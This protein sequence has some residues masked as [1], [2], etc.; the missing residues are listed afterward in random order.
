MPK[1]N[2]TRSGVSLDVDGVDFTPEELVAMVLSHAKDIT[3]AF[4]AP[5]VR[6]C[7]MTVPSFYTQ[8]ERQALLD[9][10]ELADLNV[11]GLIDENAA[12]A[13]HYGIDRVD[14]KP[15]TIL[16]YNMGGSS[17]EVSVVRYHSYE[18]KD[19]ISRKKKTVGSFEVLGKG[20]DATLGGKA[21]DAHL[22]DFL[23]TEFNKNPVMEGK[24]IR[25]VPRAMAKLR[26]QANKVK[27]V[28][29]ANTDFPVFVD[30]LY[31]DTGL[32]THIS[33]STFEQLTHELLER[34]VKPIGD[35]LEAA[36]LTLSDID[37]VELIGGGMRIPKVQEMIKS[38]LGE[39]V[40]LGRHINSDEAMALGAAFH[41]ANVSTAF[42]VRQV[43]MTDVNPFEIG[44]E[45]HELD[46]VESSGGFASYFGFGKKKE[47]EKENTE[48]EERWEKSAV[49]FKSFGKVGV[50]KTIAFSHDKDVHCSVNYN[51]EDKNLPANTEES[52]VRFK[53]TGVSSFVNDMKG[54]DLGKP[55]ISL[56]FELTTSGI[57]NLIKAEAVLEETVVVQEEI[58]VDEEEEE[59][60]GEDTPED[61]EETVEEESVASDTEKN[62]TEEPKK[63]E[64]KKKKVMVDKVRKLLIDN[65]HASI[66]S[67]D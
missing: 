1:Y 12:A 49:M 8:H 7:V 9:A 2:D 21:F 56:Q 37:Q 57:T 64:K 13:L 26:I 58:E 28:L 67:E 14:E 22:V 23:A 53:I 20:W 45:L 47:E 18:T 19:K 40:E 38:Y 25:D 54:K 17:L 60:E 16:F 29:S 5:N 44:I 52:I 62:E 15:V 34:S 61:K 55:K 3:T 31:K 46:E 51:S 24:D 33:R 42:R 35:A 30:G 11:L 43:G 27:H 39:D 48:E 41:G 63:E 4:G 65:Q 32:S 6:D 50:K 66:Q 59:K 36:N 10:A